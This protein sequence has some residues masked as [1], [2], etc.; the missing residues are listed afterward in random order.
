MSFAYLQD[1][2]SALSQHTN[3]LYFPRPHCARCLL[4]NETTVS[5]LKNNL[6]RFMIK[7]KKSIDSLDFLFIRMNADMVDE[8]H[9]GKHV[10]TTPEGRFGANFCPVELPTT[11]P[12][13]LKSQ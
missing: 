1:P 2:Q 13:S 7:H 10:Q 12:S 8:Q 9:D 3:P 6:L 4:F 5:K 11:A